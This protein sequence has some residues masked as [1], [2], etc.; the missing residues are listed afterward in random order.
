MVTISEGICPE[1]FLGGAKEPGPQSIPLYAEPQTGST[2]PLPKAA[3]VLLLLGLTK[4]IRLHGL[5]KLIAFQVL[6][7]RVR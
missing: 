4:L 3:L 7:Y 2:H 6:A 1:I 5:T